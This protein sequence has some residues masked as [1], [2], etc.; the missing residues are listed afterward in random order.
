MKTQPMQL[1]HFNSMLNEWMEK[2]R[3]IEIV[4]DFDFHHEVKVYLGSGQMFNDFGRLGLELLAD[5]CEAVHLNYYLPQHNNEINKKDADHLITNA[6]IAQGD[7]EQ[8]KQCQFMFSHFTIPEDSGLSAECGR[9]S[10]MRVA[11]PEKY[12]ASVAILDDIRS[13]TIPNPEQKGIENQTIY[14]N[15]YTAGLPDFIGDTL[16]D[17]FQFM[18]QCYLSKK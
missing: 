10:F 15:S 13:L 1:N 8:L 12:W 14:M 17:C 5:L 16:Y 3:I 11:D 6:M 4:R 2:H 18:Y 9:F 7:N